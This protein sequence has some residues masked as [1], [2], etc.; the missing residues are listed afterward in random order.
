MGVDAQPGHPPLAAGP[1]LP[2]RFVRL[3][4]QALLHPV[5]LVLEPHL[6]PVLDGLVGHDGAQ[7]RPVP[8]RGWQ[9]A[10]ARHAAAR[11]RVGSPLLVAPVE[12]SAVSTWTR[13]NPNPNHSHAR[14]NLTSHTTKKKPNTTPRQTT[15]CRVPYRRRPSRRKGG[16]L[17]TR[18]ATFSRA[19]AKNNKTQSHNRTRAFNGGN[20]GGIGRVG[21]LRSRSP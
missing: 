18:A 10:Q 1:P 16:Y 15:A 9:Q 13:R 2:R 20:I 12:G 11:A 17:Q 6:G 19:V 5:G 14:A 4:Q 8:L 7:L 3:R 21:I